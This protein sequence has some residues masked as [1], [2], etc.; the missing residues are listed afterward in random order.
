MKKRYLTSLA[1]ASIL[2][3]AGGFSA[4]AADATT[5]A[6]AEQTSANAAEERCQGTVVDDDGEPLIGATVQVVGTSQ[7]AATNIDGKFMFAKVKTG[8]TLRVTYVGY[9][10]KEIVWN[11]GPL[12]IVMTSS[13]TNLDEVVVV[14]Y[15]VQKK[16]NL[17]GAVSQVKGD[18]LAMHPVADAAQMLQGMVPGLFV[19]NSNAGRPGGSATLQLRGQ[20]NLSG[21]GSP[22]I[23]VDGVEM[24]LS[25][26][27]PNDIESISVLK[28]AG[29]SAIYGAR[30]AYGVILVTT[31]HGEEGKMRISY[32]GTVGWNAPTKLPEML[33]GY[34]F[35]KMWNAGCTNAGTARLYSD[36]KL[37]LLRQFRD[38]PSSVDPWQEVTGVSSMNPQFENSESG[39]GNTD[40]FDLH[41][42]DWAFKQSHNISATGG[43]KRA[44]YYL[45]LG[46]YDEDGILRYA[47]MGYTRYNFAAN[48]KS[49][50]TNWLT[51]RAN[52]KF[53]HSDTDTP[54]GNG[55]LSEG[56]YH[57]LA[58]F[59]PTVHYQDMNGNFTELTMIPYLQSG[60]Y[61]KTKRDRINI[62][63]GADIQ[64]LKNWHINVDYTYR[65][66]GLDYEAENV[67][68]DIYA[69]DGVTTS[70]GVRG[71]LGIQADGLYLRQAATTRYQNFNAYTNYSITVAD[72]HNFSIM[73]GYQSELNQYNYLQNYITG[74]YSTATPGLSLGSGDLTAGE[75]RT[76]WSTRGWFGR[77]N[78]DFDGRY[79]L[80]VNMRYDGTSRFAKDNRW[81]FFPSVSLGWNIAR[82][83]FWEPFNH[84][85]NN[86]KLRA[87]W[88]K[89]GNQAG[90]DLYTFASTMGYTTKG[91]YW[92]GDTRL[93]YINAPGVIDPTVT[94]EKVE[95][96]NLGLDFGFLNSAITGTF[97]IFQRDTK[98]MLG[99]GY[100][101]PDY[102][103][104][105]APQSNNANMRNRGWE[106]Q[107]NWNGRI[108]KDIT[109]SIGG[110][111]ADATAEVTEYANLDLSKE[112]TR[113]GINPSS[114]WYPGR[115]VGEIWGYKSDGI[116][117]TQEEADAFN[118]LDLSYLNGNIWTIGD[119]KY[120]DLNGDGK[121]NRGSN[122]MEDMGDYTVIG[123][124]TPRY[125]YTINGSIAWKGLSLN[126]MFQG[127]GKR[128]WNPGTMPYFW[129]W[130]SY[131]QATFFKQH[132]DYWTPENTG[133]YYP[134]PYLHT[135]GGIGIY[136]N[137]NMQTSDRYLQSAAYIRLKNITLAYEL[138]KQ[139]INHIG[140][141][142][143]QVFF[144]GENLWTSTNLAKM[145]DP[146]AIFTSNGYTSEGGKNYPMNKVI[147]F[148]LTVNL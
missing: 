53:M 51:V 8:S 138:P 104:A 23:L 65:Y 95:S 21:T 60:T 121:I 64:P 34:E 80:E 102:F 37:E 13:A 79:L 72:A 109:F 84:I 31:K 127:V 24:N 113:L 27:N 106:L 26:V 22:Y 99:P 29:A 118:A 5:T 45:S 111:V 63:M 57:S 15:G 33:D 71:E 101:F 44:Q 120:K 4:S 12:E 73:A 112:S 100:N 144:T 52:T 6:S 130:G 108:G 14:G 18:D 115:T 9:A 85:A 61:T 62:T 124:T 83:K 10:A 97:E 54:F 133:A 82:E 77:F 11:G 39:I 74:L 137:R 135:A 20:G 66:M 129:G 19:S 16:V 50:I 134:K 147:S 46:Y 89:M 55:G 38:N 146:E 141:Q 105:S 56:F 128:D 90:A 30:A 116:I 103:G 110:S 142:K 123:N 32:Q 47:D 28:D 25:D 98:D 59:R 41:Y 43:G 132:T 93:G 36:E 92:F 96:K 122:N 81:G 139:W 2:T 3:V 58:R 117:Q 143:V 87:S 7:A 69:S 75:S 91:N 48:I 107:V 76:S 126:L 1:V 125:Q 131:A 148:G 114:Q 40:Y 67:A 68:P 35:A 70:K 78:Y 145:F 88:G 94:W 42:K 136:Q 86:L 49:E 119:H 140:L 17:T